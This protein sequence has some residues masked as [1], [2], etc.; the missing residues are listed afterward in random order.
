MAT[1]ILA[2]AGS[3]IGGMLGG[4]GTVVAMLGQ[5]IG[6]V[7]GAFIDR[8][9]MRSSTSVTGSRLSDLEVQ[10]STEG[11]PIP[12]VYGRVRI[13][14]SL[15]WATRHEETT[16]V[17]ETSGGKGGGGVTT[18]NYTY[19]ANFALGL[20]EGPIHRIARV[21]ANGVLLDTT[22]FVMRV[23]PGD[24]TQEPDP[25][26]LARQ[27]GAVPAWRG[28]AVVVFEHFPLDDWGNRI[29]Q[30]TF[31][32]IRVVDDLEAK[33]RAVTLIPGA[34][35]FG[36][37]PQTVTRSLGPG[38]T[39]AEN[40]HVSIAASDFEASLDEL[41]ELCPA[42]TR[43][44]LV[45]AWFG[46][47]LRAGACRLRPAVDDATKTTAPL[48]W[49]VAG[50][51]RG[52]ARLVARVAGR[53]AYGGTPD[54]AA[55]VAA[56]RT[57]RARGI[58]VT[59]YPFVAMD[60]AAGNGLPDPQGGAEQPAFPWRG[61]IT[62]HPA[63][64]RPGTP[65][66]TAAVR[67]EI[68]AFVGAAPVSAF[69][70]VGDAVVFSGTPEWSFRR[71]ILH[72]AH[73]AVA[74]GGVDGFLI[75]SEL[76][77]LTTLRDQTGAHPFVEA[78]VALASEV[79]AVLGPGPRLTYGADWSEWFGHHPADGS[80]DVHFH[81]DPLWCAPA[82]DAIGIDAWFPLT[83]WRS[84]D[85]ADAGLADL[86]TDPA[87]LRSRVAGGENFDW[88]YASEADRRAG[89]RTPIVD[90]AYGKHWVFRPKDLIGWW[91]NPHVERRGGIETAATAW[92]PKSKPIWF[93]ELGA[94]A[95][96]LGAN[97]PSVFPDPKSVESGLPPFSS[98]ARDDLVLR[99]AVEAILDHFADPA[100]NPVSPIYGAPMLDL[101]SAYVWTWDARPFPVF[102]TA[103]DVW[104]DGPSWA[105]GHWLTG[106]LGGLSIEAL[107]RAVL[108]DHGV[109][110]VTF[111]AVA[112]H[113]DGFLVDRRMSARDVLEPVL[114][115]WCIDGVDTGTGLRFCGRNR[116]VDATLDL[117]DLVEPDNGRRLTRRRRQESEL[118]AEVSVT[119]SDAA[120][121]HRRTTVSSRRLAGG[122]H[123]AS[124][125]DLGIV[126]P[127]EAMA[128]VADVWLAD[129]WASRTEL[130]FAL[131]PTL[132][133]LEPG[134]VVDLTLPDGPAERLLITGLTDGATRAVEARRLDPAAYRTGRSGG[135]SRLGTV[136]V[137]RGA[138]L[139]EVVDAVHP[140]DDGALHRPWLAVWAS[141][142]P[143][144]LALRRRLDVGATTLVATLDRP[145]VIG[146]TLTALAPRP[147][148]LWDRVSRLDVRLWG[149]TLAAA[150][151]AR[152]LDG[153]NRAAVRT[154]AGGW[155]ILQFAGADLVAASTWRLSDL[156]RLQ[157]GSDDAFD[158]I[159]EI[160]AGARFVLLDERLLALPIARDDVGREV[161]HRL[162][163]AVDPPSAASWVDVTVTPT[164]RGLRPWSPTGLA[165]DRDPVSGDLTLRWIRRSR[166]PGADNWD[167]REVP[168]PE[169]AELWRLEIRHAGTLVTAAETDAPT[170]TWSRA[171]RDA[172]LGPAATDVE[173]AVAQI[174]P[175]WGL[176]VARRAVVHL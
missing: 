42:L 1:L 150:S 31:E 160:P 124:S 172:A 103:T 148:G 164:A 166:S 102:P 5:A 143:G 67:A 159:A 35:E 74:A 11:D 156:L 8:A 115:A 125:A 119:F 174:D 20:C 57:I 144:R 62:C 153:A 3:A 21:W 105:T 127:I 145:A 12:R 142:W 95:V 152:V 131:P 66:H 72:M 137:P 75:G 113:V 157:G 93:T 28:T 140:S 168:R 49:S 53:P 15:I 108:A 59:L 34:T 90:T 147:A 40:R 100:A 97:R 161:V 30:F 104:A 151:P 6:G 146:E 99:R 158:G 29:P 126:A 91:S 116:R 23:L 141:P 130:E 136:P 155:E 44:A 138:A 173:I 56:I 122:A 68:A 139:A 175:E 70:V 10:S 60:I 106:R 38:V 50:V 63:P 41:L 33:I 65:D 43:I 82:I 88:W 111:R 27:G 96:D 76:V 121:D 123:R 87:Y 71:L 92:V 98:G 89:H 22:R 37:A 94:P 84:G 81:L 129:L 112:G 77:G 101:A 9:L 86:P 169:S 114:A 176:G 16:V 51:A 48:V 73:L 133:A 24:E 39:A 19:H 25:L 170:W 46:D 167:L 120:L 26:V 118:P 171:A 18:T 117:D 2:A 134:D 85:H 78:L 58:A 64:G 165:V 45:V 4:A 13:A 52:E 61:R 80:G 135:R 107:I 14:G 149:G 79:R 7:A 162:G 109:D 47:D 163:P 132:I 69:S 32:V 36:Y 128:G 83:D 55:V 154:P 54:D 110:A 17:E